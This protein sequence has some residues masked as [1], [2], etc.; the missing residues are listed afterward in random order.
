MNRSDSREIMSLHACYKFCLQR[1]GAN[2]LNKFE[3]CSIKH[4]GKCLIKM[5]SVFLKP[6]YLG[7]V[8]RLTCQPQIHTVVST[9]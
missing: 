5:F 1:T 7:N 9:L 2:G 6:K 4:D 8:L 3:M